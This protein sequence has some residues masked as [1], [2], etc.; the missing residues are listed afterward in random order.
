VHRRSLTR[1]NA[2]PSRNRPSQVLRAAPP[3]LVF[4]TS[5][6]SWSL[7]AKSLSMAESEHGIFIDD[8]DFVWLAG[9]GKKDANCSSSRWTA[10]SCCRS[11]SRPGNDSNSTERSARRPTSR[12]CLGEGSFRR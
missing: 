8:N 4:D 7:A 2:P 10:S 9:N 5:A 11:A 1:A 6:I 12:R 3:V